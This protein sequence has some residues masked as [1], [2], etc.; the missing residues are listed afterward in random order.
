MKKD[1]A[2]SNITSLNS[3]SNVVPLKGEIDLHV[4]PTVTAALTEVIDQKPER[5]VV[6]L[7]EVTY[8]DSAGLAA[9]I[10]AMQKVEGY[11][12]K[13]MLSGLQETV[14]SIFEISRLDQVF[15]IFP[16]ADA[17]LAG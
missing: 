8:I 1:P 5:L 13:F 14:R 10:Q 6:D 15:Q 11:G 7:S 17:A 3:P 9:L 4:S 2:S 12:G 16:D